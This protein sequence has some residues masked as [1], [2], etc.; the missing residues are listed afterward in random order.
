[1][2]DPP[3]CFLLHSSLKRIS[4]LTQFKCSLWAAFIWAMFEVATLDGSMQTDRPTGIRDL[5]S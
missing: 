3:Q 1:V 2:R 4:C 5:C